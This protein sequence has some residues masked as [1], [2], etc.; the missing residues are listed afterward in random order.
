MTQPD[1]GAPQIY[2][3]LSLMFRELNLKL[4]RNDSKFN[5]HWTPVA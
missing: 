1:N 2:M 3:S 5:V 4:I